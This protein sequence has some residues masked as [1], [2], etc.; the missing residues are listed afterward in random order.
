M[1]F[2][3]NVLRHFA[4]LQFNISSKFL[5][6]MFHLLLSLYEYNSILQKCSFDVWISNQHTCVNTDFLWLVKLILWML[7]S[8]LI[9]SINC[10]VYKQG[11]VLFFV[12]FSLSP[13]VSSILKKATQGPF[14]S[15]LGWTF[16]IYRSYIFITP[17]SVFNKRFPSLSILINIHSSIFYLSRSLCN[18]FHPAFLTPTYISFFDFQNMTCNLVLVFLHVRLPYLYMDIIYMHW[19]LSS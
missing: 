15:C 19:Y 16:L 18:Y 5:L 7:V 4:V 14:C 11:M 12:G 2:N 9:T 3:S 10:N 6:E 17:M 13:A 1:L 8:I